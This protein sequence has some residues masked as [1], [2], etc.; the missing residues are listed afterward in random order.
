MAQMSFVLADTSRL[1]SA[2]PTL[3]SLGCSNTSKYRGVSWESAKGKWKVRIRANGRYSHIAC[4][5]QPESP[6]WERYTGCGRFAV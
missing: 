4:E 3:C 2:R 6:T 1:A 5:W